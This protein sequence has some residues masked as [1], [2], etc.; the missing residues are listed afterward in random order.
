MHTYTVQV[1]Q[2]CIPL[3]FDLTACLG[4]NNVTAKSGQKEVVGMLI[5]RKAAFLEMKARQRQQQR[6]EE[7]EEPTLETNETSWSLFNGTLV[8]SKTAWQSELG[9]RSWEPE[10]RSSLLDNHHELTNWLKITVQWQLLHIFNTIHTTALVIILNLKNPL[11]TCALVS[12]LRCCSVGADLWRLSALRTQG[13]GRGSRARPRPAVW[14]L[15]RLSLQVVA[16]LRLGEVNVV[17]RAD[18]SG[19]ALWVTSRLAV[20]LQG[21]LLRGHSGSVGRRQ[22]DEDGGHHPLGRRCWCH[23]HWVGWVSATPQKLNHNWNRNIKYN[24]IS[25]QLRH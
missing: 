19:G 25:G 23:G 9:L 12:L 11:C 1:L 4:S 7:E 14:T 21:R 15:M 16:S 3:F 2:V 10:A 17:A 5:V 24:D 22:C 20:G 8:Y 18:S 6:Q 13:F